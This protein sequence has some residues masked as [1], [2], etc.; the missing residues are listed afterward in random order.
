MTFAAQRY[1][2]D[3]LTS[4]LRDIGL[5]WM[6]YLTCILVRHVFWS[7][8]FPQPKILEPKHPIGLYLIARYLT[9]HCFLFYTLTQLI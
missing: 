4:Y 7:P 1:A 6:T 9:L 5:V 8:H 2:D 3:A